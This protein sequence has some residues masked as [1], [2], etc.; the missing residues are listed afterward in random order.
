MTNSAGFPKKSGDDFYLAGDTRG[1]LERGIA[2]RYGEHG[3]A[4][5]LAAAGRRKSEKTRKSDPPGHR[6]GDDTEDE[7]LR[8]LLYLCGTSMSVP[9]KK[10]L[11]A[12]E[13]R[14]QLDDIVRGT[15]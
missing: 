4:A 10:R 8:C 12:R 5:L 6:D 9:P 7:A 14:D 11:A 3:Q 1:A 13:I 2:F 15:L